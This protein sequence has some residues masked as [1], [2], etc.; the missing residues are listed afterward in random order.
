[1]V[2]ESTVAKVNLPD[3]TLPT[4]A[5]LTPKKGWLSFIGWVGSVYNAVPIAERHHM[6]SRYALIA[7]WSKNHGAGVQSAL[8]RL[9]P[10]DRE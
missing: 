3:P 6:R 2:N 1:M 8:S 10:E 7:K 4:D 5:I 9:Q